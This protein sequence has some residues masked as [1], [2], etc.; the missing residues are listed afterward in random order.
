MLRN[1]VWVLYIFPAVPGLFCYVTIDS[2]A[3]WE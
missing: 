3:E 2:V 1:N